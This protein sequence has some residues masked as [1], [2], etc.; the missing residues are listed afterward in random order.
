MTSPFP[1]AR[2]WSSRIGAFMFAHPDGS[3]RSGLGRVSLTVAVLVSVTL[4]ATVRAQGTPDSRA[5]V[6]LGGGYQA[7]STGFSQTITFE[8]YS[9][10]GSLSSTYTVGRRPVV[11]AGLIVRVWRSIGVGI[12]GSYFHDSGSAQV[13]ALVPNPFV[14]GQPRQ[15]SGQAGVSHTETGAHFQA[16]YWVQPSPRLEIIASGGPS[17][18]RVDQDFVSDVTYTQIYPYDTATYQGASVVRQRKTVTGGNIS[19][20][21][22]WRVARHL[23]V[24]AA[25]RFSRATAGFPGTS[26]QSL[27]IGGLR[28]GGGVRLLF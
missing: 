5:A 16:A 20:E 21:V 17:V 8:Q 28:V 2:R 15:V 26:A 10:S 3:P 13:N 22:G 14:F 25:V 7:T 19:A 9:E 11:D 27:V 4:S 24:A 1:G 23:G 12:S 6:D 18:F